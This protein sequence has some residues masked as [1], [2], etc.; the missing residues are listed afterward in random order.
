MCLLAVDLGLRTGF[1]L[2]GRNGRLQ[3]YRSQNF[4][5]TSRLKRG[6]HGLLNEI[7]D[8]SCIIVEGGGKLA[9]VWEREG[10]K[11]GVPVIF[12]S[13]ETWRKELLYPR[14]QRKGV[15]AK[16]NADDIARRVIEWSGAPRPTSLRHDAA[17]AV[18]AGL[19]GV[20]HMGWL[21]SVPNE[22]KR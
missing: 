6:V 20:V 16:A 19:W 22:I 14:E 9:R 2:Y 21:P 18:L 11:R 15:A 10:G 1:A 12:I 17:E 5:T 3:W 8:L 4:V 7:E 13:A